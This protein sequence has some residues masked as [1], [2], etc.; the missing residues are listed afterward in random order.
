VIAKRPIAELKTRLKLPV[1]ERQL[2]RAFLHSSYVNESNAGLESN[3]RLE[4][5]G[6]AVIELVV[7]EYLFRNY[8]SYTEGQLTKI[9]SVVVSGPV[10]AERARA[11]RLDRYL[12]LGHGEEEA[13][14]RQ[15]SSILGDAFEA[16][17]G[18]IF[19]AK[20]YKAATRFVLQ[21]LS[22]VITKVAQ[23]SY[24][25]DY[26]TQLQEEAQRRGL[27]PVYTL[28]EQRGADHAKEFTVQVEV[29]GCR[30]LGE[31]RRVKDAEQAAARQAYLKLTGQP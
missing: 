1:A 22:D 30:A 5:L 2:C 12:H 26:K 25:R 27:K 4:F 21:Q 13:G 3:E 14:G 20:G 8:P 11:L 28:L 17:V 6:D 31:G 9:K 23:G 29:N 15:R 19:A 7:S 16:L 24:H 18:I 10:L